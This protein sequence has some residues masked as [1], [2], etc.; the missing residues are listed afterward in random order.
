MTS[1]RSMI[2]T[3]SRISR[4]LALTSQSIRTAGRARRNA[5]ATGMACTMSPSAPSRTIRTRFTLFPLAKTGD[6]IAAGVVLPVSNN[7]RSTAVR[8]HDAALGNRLD[9][10]VGAFTVDV[11]LDQQ[12]K[13]RDSRV[14]VDDHIVD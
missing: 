14:A 10:V 7:N 3:R 13:P 8:L 4:C 1:R 9:G 12:Q 11:G 2:G 6:E 5:A